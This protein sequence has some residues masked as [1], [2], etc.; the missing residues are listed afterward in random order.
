MD[1]AA[2]IGA[3]ASGKSA[4]A[5]HLAPQLNAEIIS[6]DSGAVYR[7]MDIGTATPT[8]DMCA[9]VPHHL[10]NIIDPCDF[11]NVARF[12]HDACAAA[13]EVRARGK[14]PLFVGGS[15]M[16]FNALLAGLTK[17]PPVPA[18]ITQAVRAQAAA[19][20]LAELY[21]EL[22]QAAPHS[23]AAL[24]PNDP[25]RITRAVSLLRSGWQL[26]GKKD[27]H[28]PLRLKVV[29]LLPAQRTTLRE[30]IRARLDDMWDSGLLEETQALQQ[31]WQLPLDAPPLKMAG[32]RQAVEHLH[33]EID[34]TT[35]R[36]NAYYATSQLAK[37]Q[38]SWMQKWRTHGTVLEPFVEDGLEE[39]ALAALSA[40]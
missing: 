17:L 12:Y 9:Q 15:M 14:T 37:R 31:Q 27:T 35:M 18:G 30:R 19:G 11:Y 20:G 10:V 36:R 40:E 6:V 5:M 13:A 3:T 28:P 39:K 24:S 32:Y 21:E 16:Y 7:G 1:G 34:D 2:V 4:L 22:Q 29:L 38:L 26:D 23:A 25:Q 33:G 8:A